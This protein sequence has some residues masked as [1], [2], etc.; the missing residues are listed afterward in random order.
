MRAKS[1]KNKARV[2]VEM[3][4]AELKALLRKTVAE[5]AA[6]RQHAA[7]LEEEVM[8]WR[9]GAK[10]DKAA[11]TPS[12]AEALKGGAGA[13]AARKLTSPAPSVPPTPGRITPSAVSSVDRPDTP[14]TLSMDKDEREDFLRRENELSDQL[15][16]RVCQLTLLAFDGLIIRNRHF[17]P[18]RRSCRTFARSLPS[19]KTRRPTCQR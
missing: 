12:L 13:A 8:Q 7:T 9:N 11:W 3:S 15:A 17:Q 10:V 19:S 18:K 6:V 5:L 14:S 2:N 16:E 4:P 1:I